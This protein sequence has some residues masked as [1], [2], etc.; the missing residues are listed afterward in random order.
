MTE[1]QLAARVTE[2]EAQLGEEAEGVVDPQIL[3]KAKSGLNFSVRDVLI[4]FKI[5]GVEPTDEQK[6]EIEQALLKSKTDAMAASADRETM[7]KWE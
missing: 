7:A 2:L 4:A 6:I 3:A 1:E 5:V